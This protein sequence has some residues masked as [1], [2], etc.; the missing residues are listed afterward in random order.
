M[1]THNEP[2]NYLLKALP[3]SE[4]ATLLPLLEAVDLPRAAVLHEPGGPVTSLLFP[5]SCVISVVQPF[6]NGEDIEC[7]TV[8]CEG[9]LCLATALA[10]QDHASTRHSVQIA[11]QA[12][13][14]ARETF[15]D[16][17]DSLPEFRRLVLAYAGGLIST[18]M[19]S[20]ACNRVHDV[21]RRLARWLL[22]THDRSQV[23]EM[24]LTQDV[25]AEMLGVHRPTVS[26]AIRALEGAGLIE[27]RRG[28]IRIRDRTALEA[29]AC[30]CYHIGARRLPA[31]CG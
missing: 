25:M 7:A 5:E 10:G 22:M 23:E 31:R 24:P 9:V 1:K 8:G 14:M 4:R 15:A 29:A 19:L 17:F 6:S 28:I 3:E 2:K 26:V 12:H 30:E 18:L 13:R 11:G 16:S 20:V 27:T 21:E